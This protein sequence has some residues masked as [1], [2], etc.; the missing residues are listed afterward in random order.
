MPFR[1][2]DEISLQISRYDGMTPLL[3]LDSFAH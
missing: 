1:I 2:L 3:L